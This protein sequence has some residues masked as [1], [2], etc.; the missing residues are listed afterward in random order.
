[1][2]LIPS[3]TRIFEKTNEMY[4]HLKAYGSNATE[5]EPLLLILCYSAASPRRLKPLFFAT[6][7]LHK[8]SEAIPLSFSITFDKLPPGEYNCQVS[9]LIRK[10]REPHFGKLP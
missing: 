5:N 2:K 8:K 3:V 10:G 6:E 1:V 4:V 9:V 7:R